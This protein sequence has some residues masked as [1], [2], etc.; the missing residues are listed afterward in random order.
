MYLIND[1]ASYVFNLR[2]GASCCT[3]PD[4]QL[5]VECVNSSAHLQWK[6]E[7]RPV[8]GFGVTYECNSN[9]SCNSGTEV[10]M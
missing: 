1:P 10:M 5:T 3:H 4:I 9:A 2:I 6:S 7:E 8:F